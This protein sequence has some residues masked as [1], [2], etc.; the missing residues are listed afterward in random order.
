MNRSGIIG[1]IGIVLLILILF[2][3]VFKGGNNK[4]PSSSRYVS[5]ST[6]LN[7]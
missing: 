3:F 7:I 4:S 2:G 6:K 1:I 5:H